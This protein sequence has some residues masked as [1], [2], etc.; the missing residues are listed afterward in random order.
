MAVEPR[1]FRLLKELEEGEK[2]SGSGTYSL[3][4]DNLDDLY[5]HDW[6]GTILGPPKVRPLERAVSGE[7]TVTVA[8]DGFFCLH[9]QTL[10]TAFT[11]SR[12]TADPNTR[13]SPRLCSS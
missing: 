12:F 4:I 2:G 7:M 1:N 6:N 8:N 3:G 5:L 9:R 10:R 11:A 13:A